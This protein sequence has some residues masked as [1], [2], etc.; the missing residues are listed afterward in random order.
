MVTYLD[1]FGRRNFPAD[2]SMYMTYGLRKKQIVK[3]EMYR[4]VYF[5]VLNE[6]VLCYIPSESKVILCMF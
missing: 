1:Q 4:G 6:I 3:E 5:M 2:G